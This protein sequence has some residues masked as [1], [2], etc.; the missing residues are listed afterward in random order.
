MEYPAL[1]AAFT[2]YAERMFDES[3][4][5]VSVDLFTVPRDV[6]MDRLSE[7]ADVG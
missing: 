7:W 5:L 6:D 3:D 2:E 1:Y 4:D